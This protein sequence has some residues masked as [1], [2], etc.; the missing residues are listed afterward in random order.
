MSKIGLLYGP[1]GGSTDDIAELLAER[2]GE[3]NVERKSFSELSV[4]DIESYSK[5]IIGIPTLG[6]DSWD[7]GASGQS[8]SEFLA[9]IEKIDFKGKTVAVFGLGNSVTYSKN[10][11]DDMGLLAGKLT[12]NGATLV[13]S[14][15]VE[16]YEFDSSEA[17][18]DGKF[19]GLAI[20]EDTESEK[21]EE[22]LD[23]WVEQIKPDFEF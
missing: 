10:F 18:T 21:T 2:I 23:A 1:E 9:M 20:D 19:V 8:V 22:R 16:D 17:V 15:S 6:G 4:L 11:V 14:V 5:L 13:G 7:T 12:K 3:D